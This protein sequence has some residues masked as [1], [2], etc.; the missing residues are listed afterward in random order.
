MKF[1][2]VT[3]VVTCCALL[4]ACASSNQQND[5]FASAN[6][7][8]I[9]CTR[10]LQVANQYNTGKKILAP[11][12]YVNRQFNHSDDK[13]VSQTSYRAIPYFEATSVDRGSPGSAWRN[14]MV[15]NN[16]KAASWS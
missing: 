4:T 7:A 5:S 14:C 8:A 15:R 6:E 11:I 10:Q 16:V 2:F 3:F 1:R 12:L 9:S 13:A